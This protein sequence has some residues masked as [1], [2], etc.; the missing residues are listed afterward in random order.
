[1]D[2]TSDQAGQVK[3]DGLAWRVAAVRERAGHARN[4][5]V[6]S[7]YWR[8]GRTSCA[9]RQQTS[10]S[11]CSPRRPSS[12]MRILSF[13]AAEVPHRLLG[14]RH[15]HSGFWFISTLWRRWA[16]NSL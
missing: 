15:P 3:P 11:L 10:T 4:H 16:R 13:C 8:H 5:R 2:H 1:M 9:Q 7:R 14:R 12:T 6:V